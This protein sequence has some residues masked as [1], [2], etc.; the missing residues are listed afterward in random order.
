VNTRVVGALPPS[1][2]VGL[3]RFEPKA[4]SKGE[5]RGVRGAVALVGSE[6]R[7]I[8]PSGLRRLLKKRW[9][10]ARRSDQGRI[11]ATHLGAQPNQR[12]KLAAPRAHGVR[13]PPRQAVL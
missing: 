10:G 3:V 12:L 2:S 1:R 6:P 9:R 4:H 8:R 7:S 13:M 5:S 11:R